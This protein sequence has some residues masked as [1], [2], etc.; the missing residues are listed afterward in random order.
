M[1]LAAVLA[2]TLVVAGCGGRFHNARAS[3]DTFRFSADRWRR[4]IDAQ[5]AGK[6]QLM[7]DAIAQCRVLDGLTHQQV[8][9]RLGPRRTT[10]TSRRIAPPG[11]TR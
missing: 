4:A 11:P 10:T 7:A 9:R 3:C 2:A 6:A 5:E 1:T 8:R